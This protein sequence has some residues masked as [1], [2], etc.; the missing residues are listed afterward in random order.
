MQNLDNYDKA[1]RQE[2]FG[3]K[4]GMAHKDRIRMNK[5]G[6]DISDLGNMTESEKELY[7]VK[8]KVL[9]KMDYKELVDSGVSKNVVYFY[10]TVIDSLPVK[11]TI[12]KYML[13][14]LSDEEATEL[15]E[16]HR[17]MYVNNLRDIY[18]FMQE[19][20]KTDEDLAK[21]DEAFTS[22]YTNDISPTSYPSWKGDFYYIGHNWENKVWDKTSSRRNWGGLLNLMKREINKKNWLMTDEEIIKKDLQTIY[23]DGENVKVDHIEDGNWE[24]WQIKGDGYI[25]STSTEIKPNTHLALYKR[26]IILSNIT[27]EQ[28]F[29]DK[30]ANAI[31]NLTEQYALT[32]SQASSGKKSK[33]KFPNLENMKQEGGYSY[34]KNPNIDADTFM[35]T[36]NIRA[37][38]F[39]EWL[40][41]GETQMSMDKTF[42]SLKNMAMALNI[43]NTDIGRG[44]LGFGW[45]SRGRAGEFAHY[46][47]GKKCISQNR[48]SNGGSLAHEW[49]HFTD[50]ILTGNDT[51]AMGSE[52]GKYE[53]T[54]E[55]PALY[56]LL[57]TFKYKKVQYTKEWYD[58]DVEATKKSIKSFM[59]KHIS[60]ALYCFNDE[61]SEL[62]KDTYKDLISNTDEVKQE[63]ED[64]YENGIPSDVKYDRFM[65]LVQGKYADNPFIKKFMN[66]LDE[67]KALHKEK[68]KWYKEGSEKAKKMADEWNEAHPEETRKKS[69][70]SYHT[71]SVFG[72]RKPTYW[73]YQLNDKPKRDYDLGLEKEDFY[74]KVYGH[75]LRQLPP[76]FKK[77][78][79]ANDF[80]LVKDNYN[81]LFQ[82]FRNVAECNSE[83][84]MPEYKPQEVEVLTDFYANSKLFDG[85]YSKEAFGY[86]ESDAEM[87]A[88]AESV[89]IE[90]KL[91]A[92]GVVD[93]YACGHSRSA[94]ALTEK[95]IYPTLKNH[96]PISGLVSNTDTKVSV[97]TAYPTGDELITIHKAFDE[98]MAELKEKGIFHERTQEELLEDEKVKKNIVEKKEVKTPT[99][100]KEVE[101]KPNNEAKIQL[102]EKSAF[103]KHIYDIHK[104]MLNQFNVTINVEPKD[105]DEAGYQKTEEGNYL[106]K[107]ILSYM[108]LQRRLVS[109][110]CD[111]FKDKYTLDIN[112][113]LK[114]INKV[115]SLVDVSQETLTTKQA[116]EY[117]SKR[118]EQ[119]K[120]NPNY[121]KLSASEVAN[122]IG[123]D[124]YNL[125][126]FFSELE[127]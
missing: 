69:E 65:E 95:N 60:K 16:H 92:L 11:P 24:R 22:R 104:D 52:K 8:N 114:D 33:F 76:A 87:L 27:D 81:Y 100:S 90:E 124:G 108:N 107:D 62:D 72:R 12:D 21:W 28:E 77:L 13:Y 75:N 79:S 50:N 82:E 49:T 85:N 25:Y 120:D 46:E 99:I 5:Y 106:Q 105:L 116:I 74:T 71:L 98:Y 51:V 83:M 17:E 23:I 2:D 113:E 96:H 6:L 80:S 103:V 61:K 34:L 111:E 20:V 36:F 88:R 102:D 4:I 53:L 70:Y 56:K 45:G 78:V 91:K 44:I 30:L 115:K 18:N 125:F 127:Q 40:S 48:K 126:S 10:K 118:G 67:A 26:D 31:K 42:A 57:E 73:D 123:N 39:G 43:P 119:I 54:S 14:N 35:K 101:K 112:A 94:C 29:N 38:E 84:V 93:D 7:L 66:V 9:P 89:I 110:A 19:T 47:L 121:K 122:E 117:I 63:Y 64:E 68:Q 109:N 59:W 86:W 15:K 58:A 1:E 55:F 97:V 32:K 37:G 41:N 3:E